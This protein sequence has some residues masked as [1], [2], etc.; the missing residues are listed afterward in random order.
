MSKMT[1]NKAKLSNGDILLM[2]KRHLTLKGM[3][4]FYQMR[5]AKNTQD[6]NIYR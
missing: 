4:L 3:P 5:D 1:R 6:L 2:F